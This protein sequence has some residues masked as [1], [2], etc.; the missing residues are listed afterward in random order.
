MKFFSI[1]SL[2]ISSILVSQKL[3]LNPEI[4]QY[5]FNYTGDIKDGK[6]HGIGKFLYQN[7]DTYDGQWVN[8]LKEG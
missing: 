8:D 7:G 6:R 1:F 2:T 3:D 4:L 5:G